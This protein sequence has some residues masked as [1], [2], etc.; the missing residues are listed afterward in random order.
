MKYTT[1]DDQN[2]ILP[3]LL[4]L[5]SYDEIVESEFEGFLKAEI[6]LAESLTK[7]TKFNLNYILNIHKTALSHLYSFAG[8]YRSVN[9]SKGGFPFAAARFLPS[10]MTAFEQEILLNLPSA[11][12]I[13]D[14]LIRD[15][16]VVHGELLFIHPFREG[17]GRT[18][19]ILA[20]LMMQKQGYKRLQFEKI[21]EQEFEFY[22]LAVQQAAEKRYDKMEQLIRA[23][24]PD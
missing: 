19:R 18:A 8:K 4:G 7:R 22:V 5:K 16:A 10:T 20:N 23:I 21:G 12:K 13:K 3:N 6:M 9:L 14:D 11:Y 15:V 24:F 17:N 2:E 1:P